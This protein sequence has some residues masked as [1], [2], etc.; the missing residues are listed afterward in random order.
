MATTLPTV[1]RTITIKHPGYTPPHDLIRF[2][3]YD[4]VHGTELWGC[5]HRFVLDACR[6]IAN[7]R[8]GF[9]S[10]VPQRHGRVPDSDVTLAADVYFYFTLD[11]HE[12]DYPI[13]ADFLA[14]R[15]PDALPDHWPRPA[16]RS[17][18]R[19]RVSESAMST[20]VKSIDG[21]CILSGFKQESSCDNA[22]LVPNDQAA[23]F[24]ENNMSVHNIHPTI[25]QPNDVANGVC[26]RAD[27]HRCLDRY[28]FVFF[29]MGTQFVAYF[30]LPEEDYAEWYHRTPAQIHERVS[31]HFLYARFAF[32][33]I[34][35]LC[36]MPSTRTVPPLPAL[37]ARDSWQRSLKRRSKTASAT[38]SEKS[39]PEEPTSEP[40]LGKRT[41]DDQSLGRAF[42]ARY[43][44]L[45]RE[46][47]YSDDYDYNTLSWHP[48]FDRM[49][50]LKEAWLFRHPQIRQ[51]SVSEDNVGLCDDR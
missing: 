28:G 16:L 3:A 17:L 45:Q 41:T 46:V 23:W 20:Q 44:H 27:I 30:I 31:I 19:F 13:V 12:T 48:E 10:T 6:I 1:V 35:S 4:A 9:L 26:L 22:H 40:E 32:N 39:I 38:P 8:D 34:A 36:I 5:N 29:P 24:A 51:T 11:P 7:N 14:W 25:R 15:F 42:A 43:P 50:G 47:A 33:I 37:V 21:A 2:P 49:Q 18:Q